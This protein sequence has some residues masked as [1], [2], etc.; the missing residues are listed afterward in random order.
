MEKNTENAI[1]RLGPRVRKESGNMLCRGCIGTI[2]SSS[3]LRTN[4]PLPCRGFVGT[5]GIGLRGLSPKP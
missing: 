3:L 5:G 4:Q 2:F 1:L